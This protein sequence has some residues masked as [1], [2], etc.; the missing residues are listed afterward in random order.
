LKGWTIQ[1][2]AITTANPIIRITNSANHR[3]SRDPLDV[4]KRFITI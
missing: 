2:G 3:V 1:I 4:E